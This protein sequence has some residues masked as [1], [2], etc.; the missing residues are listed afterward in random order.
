MAFFV[1][2]TGLVTCT[3][4]NETKDASSFPSEPRKR[5]GLKSHCRKC[6]GVSSAAWKI[7]H[8]YHTTTLIMKKYGITENEY[9]TMMVLQD[10]CCAICKEDFVPEVKPIVDHDHTTGEVR[11]LLCRQCNSALGFFKDDP[12]LLDKAGRYLCRFS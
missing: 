4:C 7:K 12:E 10:S 11:G 6:S 8:N 2:T 5:N 3:R 1:R 9:L